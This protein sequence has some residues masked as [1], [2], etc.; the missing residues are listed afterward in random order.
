M[1][2]SREE[3]SGEE[4]AMRPEMRALIARFD[5]KDR[6]D[7]SPKEPVEKSKDRRRRGGKPARAA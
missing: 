7:E 4:Q 1:A 6:R 2:K 5:A 3:P